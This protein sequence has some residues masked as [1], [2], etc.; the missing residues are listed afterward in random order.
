MK[1]ITKIT[2]ALL[3]IM[4][5]FT[6]CSKSKDEVKEQETN[7]SP[8]MVLETNLAIGQKLF[9]SVDIDEEDR[10]EAWIDLNNNG[11][12]EQNESFTEFSLF[13]SEEFIIVSKTVS[14]YGKIKGISCHHNKLASFDASKNPSLETLYCGENELTS[15]N[16]SN[17]AAL[18]DLDCTSNLLQSLDL[19]KCTSLISLT[20]NNNK[21]SSLDI[22][23]NAALVTLYLSINQLSNIDLSKNTKLEALD[24]SEN[25]LTTLNLSHNTKLLSLYCHYNKINAFNTLMEMVASLPNRNGDIKG[26]AVVYKAGGTKEGNVPPNLQHHNMAANK[27]W[28]LE[29]D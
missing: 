6:A 15:L 19:S 4:L 27:N 12:R 26:K 20:C 5:V 1:T 16:I 24:C 9:F 7:N 23:N 11:K 10:A 22:S 13:R 28:I 2:F 3:A 25:K 18:I 21:L 29:T 17:N 14:I 8:K